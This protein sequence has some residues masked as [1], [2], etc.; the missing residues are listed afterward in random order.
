MH[1]RAQSLLKK[2]LCLWGMGYGGIGGSRGYKRK[3]GWWSWAQ[4]FERTDHHNFP[5]CGI[6]SLIDFCW[7]KTQ[8][9]MDG[10]V[11][12]TGSVVQQMAG[13]TP[14][15]C[16]K[17]KGETLLS[18]KHVNYG[19]LLRRIQPPWGITRVIFKRDSWLVVSAENVKFSTFFKKTFNSYIYFSG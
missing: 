14:D 2:R 13:Q 12:V 4:L 15:V 3:Q 6:L 5:E 7:I 8:Y 1:R 10:R 11:D 18:W 17:I 9:V 16:V 19:S